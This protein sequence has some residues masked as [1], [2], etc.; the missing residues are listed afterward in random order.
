MGKRQISKSKP[1][2]LARPD[3]S[4][5]KAILRKQTGPV[6]GIDEAGRGPLAGPVVAA[7]VVLDRKAIPEGLNDSKKLSASKR[8][9]LFNIICLTAH[10]SVAAASQHRI[11]RTNIRQATLYA[12]CRALAG[13]SIAPGFA[14]VDGRDVPTDLLCPGEAVVKGDSRSVSIAAASIIAKVTRDRMM[15]AA[16][17]FYP[18]Y[19][20][21]KHMGYGTVAHIEA[22]NTL[23]AC[24]LHRATFR[25]VTEVLDQKNSRK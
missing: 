5:E 16:G 3:F 24:P 2:L 17:A 12:M 11:D 18:G 6:A 20:F 19:G 22:L 9:E 13:L 10:V 25:P 1:G 21:E 23:G 8:E 15:R 4:L 7:A 14:L